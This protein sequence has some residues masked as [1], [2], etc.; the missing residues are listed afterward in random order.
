MRFIQ[1]SSDMAVL[2]VGVRNFVQ[3]LVMWIVACDIH[4]FGW[5]WPLTNE[6]RPYHAHQLSLCSVFDDKDT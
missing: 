4:A 1:G 5:K 6:K 3:S 2:S